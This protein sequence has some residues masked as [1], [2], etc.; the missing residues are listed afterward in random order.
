MKAVWGAGAGVVGELGFGLV[1][2]VG[3]VD[4][5]RVGRSERE[6]VRV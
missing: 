5:V 2:G 3:D 4:E 1:L 6:V